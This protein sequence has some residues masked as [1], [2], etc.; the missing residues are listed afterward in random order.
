MR[1]F[2]Q[3]KHKLRPLAKILRKNQTLW[4]AKIWTHLRN[5]R[6]FPIKFK[7]QY[8]VGKFIVDFCSPSH[9]LVIE[10]DG[11]RHNADTNLAQDRQRDKYLRQEGYKILRFWNNEIE[12]NLAG[13][14]QRI[15]ESLPPPLPRL[16]GRVPRAQSR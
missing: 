4:E 8:V 12:E 2:N 7:R 6:V 13:A 15:R 14:M 1:S 3:T 5:Q 11:G 16:R 9:K 10:L